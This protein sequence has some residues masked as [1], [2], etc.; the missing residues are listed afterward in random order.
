MHWGSSLEKKSENFPEGFA[1]PPASSERGGPS[2]RAVD[3]ETS[4]TIQTTHFC[5]TLS[6]YN[7]SWLGYTSPTPQQ[8][9]IAFYCGSAIVCHFI[10]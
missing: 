5:I 10:R 9:P 8:L 4:L 3:P 1:S 6:I 2:K 7:F